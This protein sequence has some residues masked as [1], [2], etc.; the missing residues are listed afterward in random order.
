MMD[1]IA[2]PA[3]FQR[4]QATT[5][6]SATVGFT[7]PV[8]LSPPSN[9]GHPVLIQWLRSPHTP[10]PV[11]ITKKTLCLFKIEPAVHGVFLE[12]VFSF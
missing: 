1:E 8:T 4:G 7:V 12:Y 10:S 5:G 3:R 6:Y 2:I 9:L 11:V